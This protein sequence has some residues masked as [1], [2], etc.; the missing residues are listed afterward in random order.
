MADA[1]SRVEAVTAALDYHRL[2]ESQS[3]DEELKQLLTASGTSLQLKKIK[4]IGSDTTVYCDV[5]TDACRPYIT[6]A[7]RRQ[8]FQSVHGIAHPGIK[9]TVRL[10]KQRFVWPSIDRDCRK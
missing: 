5:S 10:V 2:A 3:S 4:P 6:P 8:A 7:Y 1:L 9:T